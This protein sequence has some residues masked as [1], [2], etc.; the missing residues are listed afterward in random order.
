[1]GDGL[2]HS[3]KKASFFSLWYGGLIVLILVCLVGLRPA[4]AQELAPVDLDVPRLA[5]ETQSELIALGCEEVDLTN[6]QALLAARAQ[7]WQLII[8]VDANGNSMTFCSIQAVEKLQPL[9]GGQVKQAATGWRE[10]LGRIG[11]FGFDATSFLL[12][13][14]IGWLFTLG[15]QIGGSVFSYTILLL[16]PLFLVS[17]HITNSTVRSLWPIVLGIV[18]LGFMLALVFIALTTVLRLEVGGG[19]RRSLPRLLLAALLVNF[20]LVI[21][22]VVID[23]TRLLIRVLAVVFSVP[24]LT[25]DLPGLLEPAGNFG[26]IYEALKTVGPTWSSSTNALRAFIGML[27]VWMVASSGLVLLFNLAMRYIMLLGLLIVSP[28]AYLFVALPNTAKL[29]GLW[30]SSFFKYVFYAPAALLILLLVGKMSQMSLPGI[31]DGVAS[32]LVSVMFL[33]VGFIAAAR[34]GKYAGIAGSAAMIS[35]AQ[36]TGQKGRNL[37]YRGARGMG[38]GYM[39]ATGARAATKYAGAQIGLF[40]RTAGKNLLSYIPGAGKA[41]KTKGGPMADRL[42]PSKGERQAR[43]AAVTAARAGNYND[44]SLGSS[45]L[46][47]SV[48]G[49]HLARQ[50]GPQLAN[51]GAV[52]TAS[53]INAAVKNKE[54]VRNLDDTQ[55]AN[56][57][58]QIL[59]NTSFSVAPE[60][61]EKVRQR[62]INEL[63]NTIRDVE[64]KDYKA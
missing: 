28:F 12:T 32:G 7:S 47:N 21:A 60:E 16:T 42:L 59:V 8:P 54:L 22:G 56:L 4:L 31:T 61:N 15:A 6:K 35:F 63:N 40:G 55:R 13:G 3:Y 17:E 14:S 58:A 2:F 20:S 52:G 39:A 34:A 24:D 51:M 9:R 27:I 49:A 50:A 30:W 36:K 38:R 46:A 1:M 64:S 37:M 29:A 53:Q 18:N 10:V 57:E 26:P 33:T 45:R 43:A 44:P 5:H 25:S 11:L 62:L 41:A 23:F 48:V 19:V